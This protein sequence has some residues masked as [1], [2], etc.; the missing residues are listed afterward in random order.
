MLTKHNKTGAFVGN[1]IFPILANNAGNGD[2]ATGARATVYLSSAL[3]ILSAIVT[4]AFLPTI[5]QDTITLEDIKFRE[6]LESQG[7][8]TRQMGIKRVET[9]DS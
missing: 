3:C 8:D 6:Y 4:F 5:N 1:Y 2:E 7:W 9:T